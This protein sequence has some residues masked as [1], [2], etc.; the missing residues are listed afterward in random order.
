MNDPSSSLRIELRQW[1]QFVAL[2]EELQRTVDLLKRTEEELD[3]A[4]EESAKSRERIAASIAFF[5]RFASAIVARTSLTASCAASCAMP[6]AAVS[7]SSLKRGLPSA[8][9]GQHGR[10]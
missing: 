3:E 9:T 7:I 6:L 10:A 1:R 8:S 2:A 4:R 5:L